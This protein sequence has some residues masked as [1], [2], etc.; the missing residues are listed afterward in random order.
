MGY[1]YLYIYENYAKHPKQMVLDCLIFFFKSQGFNSEG[2][3]LSSPF[4]FSIME[5]IKQ[6]LTQSFLAII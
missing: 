3:L 5:A 6:K 4:P 1:Q 2:R